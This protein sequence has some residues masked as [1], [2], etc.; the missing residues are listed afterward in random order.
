MAQ[1]EH[2]SAYD[3][4][5]EIIDCLC[6]RLAAEVARDTGGEEEAREWSYTDIVEE[7]YRVASLPQFKERF[8]AFSME[9][10]EEEEEPQPQPGSSSTASPR[11]TAAIT[12]AAEP[13]AE[14]LTPSPP[15]SP[16]EPFRL[17]KGAGGASLAIGG[18]VCLESNKS[19][20]LREAWKGGMLVAPLS[21][22]LMTVALA[23]GA[24]SAQWVALVS[25]A[26]GVAAALA[27]WW[28]CNNTKDDLVMMHAL[29]SFEEQMNALEQAE[30]RLRTALE[31]M[32][33]ADT[34]M[35]KLK[36]D[37]TAAT[38]EAEKRLAEIQKH[39][40]R[41]ACGTRRR[42]LN[43]VLIH[44]ADDNG[45]MTM[46]PVQRRKIL[47]LFSNMAGRGANEMT[48]FY[49]ALGLEYAAEAVV[50]DAG[51]R[52]PSEAALPGDER[53]F[54]TKV[55]TTKD[56]LNELEKLKAF[57]IIMGLE[58]PG[59]GGGGSISS[60]GGNPEQKK[61]P[62]RPKYWSEESWQARAH[63]AAAQSLLESPESLH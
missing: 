16:P 49:A 10:I 50:G 7:I 25:A 37:V 48:S 11:T 47:E 5:H 15:A 59:D 13:L 35:D 54:S 2:E 24:G 9:S 12:P 22:V 43:R 33:A 61:E 42:V 34:D 23:T 19:W 27:G 51:F 17:M 6:K 31:T 52:E 44:L 14:E 3:F 41:A 46:G 55:M 32:L 45:S 40:E 4:L 26:V 21:V 28:V 20:L 58:D 53:E 18:F 60:S 36:D 38:N 1:T 56:V 62:A 8:A 30:E 57:E 29:A 39:N 63:R